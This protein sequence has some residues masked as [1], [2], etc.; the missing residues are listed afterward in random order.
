MDELL[1]LT[2]EVN[3]SDAEYKR[4]LGYPAHYE[5][6]E[7]VASLIDKTKQWYAVH[8]KPWVYIR[9]A[10][11]LEWSNHV[12]RINDIEFASKRLYEY[13]SN[14]EADS[15]MLVAVSAG[16]ACEAKALE[17]WQEEKPDEYF[18][19]EMYGS[20]VVENLITTTGAR[21]CAWAD[22]RKVAVLP[23]YSPGYPE[24]DIAQQNK[25][26][27]IIREKNTKENFPGELFVMDSGMLNPKKSLLA[28]FGITSRLDKV[29]DLRR[30]IPCENCSL[31]SCSYRRAPYKRSITQTESVNN[32]AVND[33]PGERADVKLSHNA[34]YKINSKALDKWCKERLSLNVLDDHSFEAHFRYDGTTCANTGRPLQFLYRVKLAAPENNYKIL[35]A[36]CYPAPGDTGHTFMC[37]YTKD[38]K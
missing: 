6:D 37:Q 25:L 33:K 24:W 21:L 30:L 4:L 19:M 14:A 26:F 15:A 2:P 5:F 3:V 8:G 7:R 18:F 31:E 13:L 11:K 17:L 10:A 35:E 12:F 27:N 32:I 28:V 20:A 29:N 23:H 38:A 16:K 34:S 9:P 1:D 22:E 36:Y